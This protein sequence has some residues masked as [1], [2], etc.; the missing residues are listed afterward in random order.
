M[1]SLHRRCAHAQPEFRPAALAVLGGLA[2]VPADR[3]VSWS[4]GSSAIRPIAGHR[5]SSPTCSGC[6]RVPRHPSLLHAQRVGIGVHPGVSRR[7]SIATSQIREVRDDESRTFAAH[8]SRR[9]TP[10]ER[11]R[12]RKARA[13]R[14]GA[15]GIAARRPRRQARRASTQAAKAVRD[16]W[17]TWRAMPRSCS[18]LMLL[19]DAA[20]LPGLVRRRRA[21][22]AGRAVAAKPRNRTPHRC[23]KAAS[24]RIRRSTC[25]RPF[26]D[27]IERINTASANTSP[28]GRS[29]R[30]SSTTTR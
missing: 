6:C 17:K 28:I 7:S 16:H 3:D 24:A 4:R 30:C 21:L 9:N 10:S 29:S 22:G 11:A 2:A 8:R 18:A 12:R 20:L 23:T 27:V 25:T 26:T 1:F 15:A 19:V 14:R 5:C 13:T